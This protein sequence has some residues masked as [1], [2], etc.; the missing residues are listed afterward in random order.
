MSRI[1]VDRITDKA[2]TGAPTLVNGMNVT[3]QSTMNNIVGAAVT[4]NSITGDVTGNLT[5]DV[6][7]NVTGS[8]ANLTNLP[9]GQLTGA[10]PAISGA[11][12]TNISGTISA[13]SYTVLENTIVFIS[14][15]TNLCSIFYSCLSKKY[16]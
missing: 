1:K 6:T 5:G 9:A 12:L 16:V 4:F 3:G 7:G 8:G 2:G 11:S 10:L 14:E 15:A 13:K